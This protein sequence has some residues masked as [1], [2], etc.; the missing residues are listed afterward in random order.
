MNLEIESTNFKDAALQLELL[1]CSAMNL[2]LVGSEVTGCAKSRRA[3][4]F[5][6]FGY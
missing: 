5:C 1:A 3:D 4:L 6:W 2:L